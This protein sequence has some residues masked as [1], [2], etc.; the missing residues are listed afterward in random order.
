MAQI[1]RARTHHRLTLQIWEDADS[2]TGWQLKD[3]RSQKVICR[4][5]PSDP[6]G[7]LNVM[8]EFLN[9]SME[10]RLCAEIDR[11]WPATTLI[12]SEQ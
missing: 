6:E 8:R 5:H 9:E 12:V 3:Q 10:A 2:V 7:T 4:S 11:E 1:Q